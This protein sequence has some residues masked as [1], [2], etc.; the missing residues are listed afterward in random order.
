M[1]DSFYS[2]SEPFNSG[3]DFYQADGVNAIVDISISSLLTI[4]SHRIVFANISIDS[5][6]NLIS[7]SHKIAFASANLAIDGA[8]VVIGTERQDGSVVITAEVFVATNAIKIAHASTS[9][10][11]ESN[12]GSIAT[13]LSISSCALSSDSSVSSSV[14][15]IA[16]ALSQITPSSAMTVSGT[17]IVFALTNLSSQINVAIL[18]KIA[19]ATI[20]INLGQI[21]NITAGAIKF[22]SSGIVDSS[23]IRTF[24]LLDGRAIT[25]HNRIFD[26][27]LEPIFTQNKNWNNRK[28][29]Y[30]KSTSRSGRRTF[31]L[32]WS[33]LPNLL[34]YTA[35]QK[36]A[37][38]Y[39]KTIASD[40]SHHV[41]KIINLDE[42]GLTPPTETSYNVLVKDYNESLIRR[43]LSNDVYFWDCSIT[44]EEV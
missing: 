19:L 27:G 40:P 34:E 26:S 39:I 28:T 9:L 4:T 33:W 37:R 10:S 25:N 1:S 3:I 29:R 2:F 21:V 12:V 14:K 23:M 7:N 38:D 18:G 44:L 20:K 32:S 15:K 16:K 17:K 11:V 31:S 5:N 30:Y 43:D 8:T 13:K 36:E 41:L 24:M 42:S 35:D 6:S 22:S